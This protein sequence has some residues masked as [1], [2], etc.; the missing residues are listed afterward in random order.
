MI[1]LAAPLLWVSNTLWTFIARHVTKSFRKTMRSLVSGE[2]LNGLELLRL[3][4]IKYAGGAAE[5]EVADLGAL[6]SFPQCPDGASLQQ[7]LGEWLAL[8]QEQG[9]DL[10]LAPYHSAHSHAPSRCP[11]GCE[12][13]GPVEG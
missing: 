4:W 12:T 1:G 5:V 13:H 3:M 8:V 11:R 9:T 7:Y 10:P 2:E 6:H